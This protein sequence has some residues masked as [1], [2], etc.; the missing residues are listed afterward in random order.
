MK[1]ITWL[2]NAIT[3]TRDRLY[4]HSIYKKLTTMDALKV[5][6]S[7][8]VFAV[9]DFMNLLTSLQQQLTS[10]TVPWTP[11]R[12]QQVARFINEIKLEEESDIIDGEC[13]S[14]FQYYVKSMKKL[15]ID[16]QR[17]ETFQKL[18]GQIPYADLISQA[19][20]PLAVQ[21]F[22]Q[23]TFKDIQSGTITT[24]A[25]FTFARETIIPTMFVNILEDAPESGP[26]ISAFKQ[27]LQRH[28]ELDGDEHGQI[29]LQLVTE[30]CGSS[31]EKWLIA[32]A[33]AKEAILA[34]I[35]LYDAI[36]AIL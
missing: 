22:L 11:T 31:D 8:H 32:E 16:I 29:A 20:V 35:H 17:I 23:H 36:E 24:S 18:I 25:S 27:Y 33:G 3:P 5:F 9:W 2:E 34:R 1:T 7:H 28:I 10:T 6:M 21:P 30:L 15:D 12:S 19:C 4:N 26:D 14:H 13:T